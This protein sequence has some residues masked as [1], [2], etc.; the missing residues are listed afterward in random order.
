MIKEGPHSPHSNRLTG[1]QRDGEGRAKDLSLGEKEVKFRMFGVGHSDLF[2]LCLN[3]YLYAV[4][5]GLH[6]SCGTNTH[7]SV[8]DCVL[9]F[10]YEHMLCV[11][12][13]VRMP[14]PI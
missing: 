13:H 2:D 3:L 4:G 12:A 6:H 8:G 11:C 5:I 10:V 1:R 14:R 7:H 9:V